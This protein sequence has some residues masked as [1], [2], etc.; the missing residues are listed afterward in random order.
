MRDEQRK[1]K[2]KKT[3][4]IPERTEIRNRRREGRAMK[5]KR[6]LVG[7]R[8]YKGKGQCRKM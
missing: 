6:N 7:E 2:P 5:V 1:S 4:R 3:K 8:T